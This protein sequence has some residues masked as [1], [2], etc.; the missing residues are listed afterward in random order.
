MVFL[1]NLLFLDAQFQ[2]T[3]DRIPK[4][5][6]DRLFLFLSDSC[7]HMVYLGLGPFYLVVAKIVGA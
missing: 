2:T 3:T 5:P 1:E 6:T 4:L 7:L